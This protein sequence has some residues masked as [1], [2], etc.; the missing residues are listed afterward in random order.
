MLLD[1]ALGARL[2]V[3]LPARNGS[4]VTRSITFWA[5]PY[6][7]LHEVGGRGRLPVC[8]ASPCGALRGRV[9]WLGRGE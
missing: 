6:L 2:Y 8:V 7:L 4:Y 9:L 3:A 1:A 5:K